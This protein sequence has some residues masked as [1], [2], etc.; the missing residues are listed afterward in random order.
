MTCTS[1]WRPCSTYRSNSM[2]SSPKADAASRRA[3][4][5]ASGK[6]VASVRTIRMPLPPPPAAALTSKRE[7]DLGGDRLEVV[8]A[9][10]VGGGHDRDTGR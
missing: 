3:A 9:V 2:V 4:A 5:T 10:G 7:A 1:M 8:D 6:L